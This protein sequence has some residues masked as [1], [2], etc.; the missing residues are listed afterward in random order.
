[1]K[2]KTVHFFIQPLTFVG[3]VDSGYPITTSFEILAEN[4]LKITRARI[5]STSTEK[6]DL[7]LIYDI[8]YILPIIKLLDLLNYSGWP[9]SDI[10]GPAVILNKISFKFYSV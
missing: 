7:L 6:M 4:I 1:M 8:N 3:W 9:F 2:S 5:S 10:K